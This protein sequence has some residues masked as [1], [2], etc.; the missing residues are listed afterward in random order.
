MDFYSPNEEKA[1]N[2]NRV[3]LGSGEIISFSKLN[4]SITSRTMQEAVLKLRA[5]DD[6]LIRSIISK[7]SESEWDMPSI[8]KLLQKL[9]EMSLEIGSNN[10]LMRI[11]VELEK[12]IVPSSPIF[13]EGADF[14]STLKNSVT[15]KKTAIFI[16]LESSYLEP[17]I[18]HPSFTSSQVYESCVIKSDTSGFL[19]SPSH[20]QDLILKSREGYEELTDEEEEKLLKSIL[21]KA[22]ESDY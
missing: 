2:G 1:V 13:V 18:D 20:I 6:C 7:V 12:P 4:S 10:K 17:N 5:G 14:K 8:N 22:P 16:F 3:R 11:L 9:A 21:A 15:W 19:T